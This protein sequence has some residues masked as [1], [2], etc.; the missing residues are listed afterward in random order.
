MK[1][2]KQNL[3]FLGYSLLLSGIALVLMMSC[4]KGTVVGPT[5]YISNSTTQTTITAQVPVVSCTSLTAVATGGASNSIIMTD[6]L[7]YK[8][9]LGSSIPNVVTVAFTWV[10]TGTSSSA[11]SG[12]LTATLPNGLGLANGA[13][14][15]TTASIPA[16]S[17]V[18]V[19]SPIVWTISSYASNAAGSSTQI[20]SQTATITTTN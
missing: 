18:G 5:Y 2:N 20:C 7:A 8:G 12:T 19:S 14:T 6:Y 3:C 4:E 9:N 15:A 11:A 13:F 10:A 17:L 1:L 16:S